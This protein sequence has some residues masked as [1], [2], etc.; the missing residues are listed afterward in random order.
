MGL[1]FQLLQ[2]L[3]DWGWGSLFATE[4]VRNASTKLKDDKTTKNVHIRRLA[5]CLRNP[6]NAERVVGS[7]IPRNLLISTVSLEDNKIDTVLLPCD[8]LHWL[9]EMNPRRFNI[10]MGAKPGS[11]AR[12]FRRGSRYVEVASLAQE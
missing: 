2:W 11:I 10:H 5:R 4:V 3:R 9:Q 7:I 12:K 8:T 6:N 1:G